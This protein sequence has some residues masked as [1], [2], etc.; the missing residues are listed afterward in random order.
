MTLTPGFGGR[1]FWGCTAMA[2]LVVLQLIL[3]VAV[4]LAKG[5]ADLVSSLPT[6]GPLKT[7]Q[8]AGFADATAD[9]KNKLFYWFCESDLG[10][11][12]DV[13]LMVWFNG[14]P[15]ASSITG[16]L[17]ENLGPQMITA[18]GT[19]VDNPHRFTRTR[20]LMVIDNPVGSGYSFTADG[21]YASSEADVRTQ[22]A[23]AFRAFFA[24]HPEYATSPLWIAG[25]SYGGKYVPNVALE[26]AANVSALHLRGVVVGNGLFDMTTQYPTVGAMALGAGV[27]DENALEVEQA[28]ESS[29]VD[30]IARSPSTAGAYCE[31]A[32]VKWLYGASGPAGEL[33]YYD[34]GIADAGFFDVVTAEMGKYLNR[35]DVRAALHVGDAEWI[36]HDETGLA[37]QHLQGDW[38]VSSA[39]VYEALLARGLRVNM[40]NGV[41]DLS[42][43][44]H[45]GNIAVAKALDWPG[46]E[47]FER[48]PALPWPNAT[49]VDAHVRGDGDLVYATILRTGHLVPITVPDVFGKLLDRF[50]AA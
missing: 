29:C 38:A 6:Y 11:G 5:P 12:A 44:N 7:K 16:L 10:A 20:H 47:A 4:A 36:Q 40:Y 8:Y 9:G 13:P 26:V 41:R 30:E 43:C 28:R 15:G 48:A 46:A 25:E 14:G 18:N 49:H 33:F 50:L 31:N 32:T 37:A 34:V 42:V 17:A 3:A 2:R 21:A 35:A 23:A 45:L 19:L 1:A 27:I 24:L 22:V 39:P